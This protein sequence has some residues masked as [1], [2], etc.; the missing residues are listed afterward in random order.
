MFKIVDAFIREHAGSEL[1]LD[2]E[3]SNIPTVARF[4][5]GFGARPEIYQGVSFD[6]LP[7]FLKRLRKAD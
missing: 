7:L 1:I 3:G 6:R 2:F 4:F 5:A